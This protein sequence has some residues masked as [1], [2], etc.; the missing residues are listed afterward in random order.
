[1]LSFFVRA[2]AGIALCQGLVACS[3][4]IELV[5]KATDSALEAVG[6][7]KPE[8]AVDLPKVPRKVNVQFHP[9]ENLNAGQ[10]EQPLA[11]VVRVYKLRDA[12]AFVRLPYE[13]FSSP[14]RE[15]EALGADLADVREIQLVPGRKV[16]SIETVARDAPYLGVVALFHAP[17]PNRWHFAFRAEDA[18]KS[19]IVIGAHA[20]ALSVTRGAPHDPAVVD[21]STLAGMQCP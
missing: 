21:P 18:E 14:V 19:G 16:E 12:T 9:G 2:I 15:K 20:C 7:K 8:A 1:M 4:T 3:T 6:V 5:G 11:L 13:T 17:A 10:T